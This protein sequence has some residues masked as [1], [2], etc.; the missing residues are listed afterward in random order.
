[1][2]EPLSL[3]KEAQKVD[4]DVAIASC[5]QCARPFVPRSG[6]GGKTQKFCSPECRQSFHSQRGQHGGSHVGLTH[7]D[8]GGIALIEKPAAAPP[9]AKRDDFYNF[10]WADDESICLRDQP[11][12]AIYENSQRTIIIRQERSWDEENDSF[13]V[14]DS[15]HVFHV[16]R[17]ILRVAGHGD[18][19]LVRHL[20]GGS[21]EDVP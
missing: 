15:A 11:A 4:A 9:R 18:V 20:G 17:Q 3:I 5:K 10:S 19:D 14:I 12:T 8:G 6:S 21:Y 16:V 7:G 1:M 13:V 2:N